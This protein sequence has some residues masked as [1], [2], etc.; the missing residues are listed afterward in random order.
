MKL[1][2]VTEFYSPQGGGVRTYLAEKTRWLA[3]RHD[4]QHVIVV[5]SNRTAVAQWE[6]SRVYLVRGP[7]V[8]LLF[9]LRVRDVDC[10]FR[11]MRREIFDWMRP[12]EELVEE[13]FQRLADAGKLISFPY[14][15]FWACMDTFKEKQ[16]LEDLY[17]RGQVPW[18]VWKNGKTP[19]DHPG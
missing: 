7:A 9:Q 4:V 5:P 2:D 18:E 8:K 1:L 6:R 15:D 17:T 12:G 16:L 11:L 19:P 14:D 13:P 3:P 10:D